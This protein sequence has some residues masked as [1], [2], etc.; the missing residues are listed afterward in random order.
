M[1]CPKCEGRLMADGPSFRTDS[2][3]CMNCGWRKYREFSVRHPTLKD[4]S[5]MLKKPKPQK[6]RQSHA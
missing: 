2:I 5:E 4:S 3:K 6:R 1:K